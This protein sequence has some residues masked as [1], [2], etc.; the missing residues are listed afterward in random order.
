MS[1][2]PWQLAHPYTCAR[3]RLGLRLRDFETIVPSPERLLGLPRLPLNPD[4][5]SIFADQSPFVLNPWRVPIPRERGWD[6]SNLSRTRAYLGPLPATL[7]WPGV[8][9]PTAIFPPLSPQFNP[10]LWDW[11]RNP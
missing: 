3:A 8:I 2:F 9:L 1:D 10:A 4:V 7:E 5:V 11:L 6:P